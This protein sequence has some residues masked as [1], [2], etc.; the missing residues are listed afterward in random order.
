MDERSRRFVQQGVL[1]TALEDPVERDVLVNFFVD[2]LLPL[3]VTT[4]K[5][6][7]LIVEELKKQLLIGAGDSFQT[8]SAKNKIALDAVYSFLDKN[9][10]SEWKKKDSAS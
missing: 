8:L 9:F 10:G 1:G 2:T 3:Q 5:I 4:E 7:Q 6:A